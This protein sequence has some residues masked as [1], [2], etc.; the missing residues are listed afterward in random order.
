MKTL[1]F[2][3]Y[4]LNMCSQVIQAKNGRALILSESFRPKIANPLAILSMPLKK[5][6]FFTERLSSNKVLSK[7]KHECNRE[8]VWKLC[9]INS[10]QNFS[11]VLKAPRV[12]FDCCGFRFISAMQTCRYPKLIRAV[13]N[14]LSNFIQ[15]IN[16]S[17]PLFLFLTQD[18]QVVIAARNKNSCPNGCHGQDR[19]SPSSPF[20]ITFHDQIEV[21]PSIRYPTKATH[22]DASMLV[23][24]MMVGD[25][26]FWHKVL[27]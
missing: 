2:G 26:M 21:I 19:L 10:L 6:R 12:I 4:D 24:N 13:I 18:G 17:P 20:L 1:L 27:A 11:Q 8:L 25:G 5:L 14:Y 15:P 3:G 22:R 7:V 16:S 23:K 9:N